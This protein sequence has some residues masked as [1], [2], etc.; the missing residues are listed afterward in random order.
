[1]YYEV[2]LPWASLLPDDYKLPSGGTE[3]K[4]ALILNENDGLG[5][6]GYYKIGDGIG[7]GKNSS[8]F[9]TILLAE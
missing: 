8:K 5:R 2:K 6:K 3:F 4:F 9:L 1:M 7:D